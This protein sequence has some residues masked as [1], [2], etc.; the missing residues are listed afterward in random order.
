MA[1]GQGGTSFNDGA[2]ANGGTV[3][4]YLTNGTGD[5]ILS[6]CTV[7]NIPT[8]SG[9]AIGGTIQAI[10]TGN[11]YVNKGTTSAAN[12]VL[13]DSGTA[14][15]LPTAASD[16]TT[17]TG[18]SFDLTMS[19]LTTGK[20]ENIT[21][22]ALTTGS[23]YIA[24]LG[25]SLTTGG[26]FNAS[27]GAAITGYALSSTTTGV[28]TG[29]GLIQ[30]TANNATTG[31]LGFISGTGLTSGN[32]WVL[33]G[34]GANMT[35]AGQVQL[36][37]MGAATTGQG[38]QIT[39]TGAYTGLNGILQVTANSATTGTIA[40]INGTALTS[41]NGLYVVGGGA[42]MLTGGNV[43]NFDMGAA[44]AGSAILAQTSGVYIGTDGVLRISATAA[45]SGN[46]GVISVTGLTTG[47]GLLIN[48]T[49]ATLTT[50]RYLSCNDATSEVFGVGL[51]GHLI[52]VGTAAA[53]SILITTAQ[54]I[55][56]VALT[57]GATDTCGI[58]TST[59]TQNNTADST[60]TLTFGK[61]YTV[62]PK[63]V[64]ITASNASAALAAQ[65]GIYVSSISATAVVF[66]VPK[67]SAAGA[68]PSWRYVIIS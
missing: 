7:A 54:G 55:T 45:T 35:S 49:A 25:T 29:A 20:G 27:L 60:F 5:W 31:V 6:R 24:T 57:A 36:I 4:H 59:G 10:D 34:G 47:N 28:Y 11:S 41:G 21:A 67:S 18:T 61:T 43:G 62:A 14:F 13:L 32:I 17:T 16:A 19:T 68:T 51:N 63:G 53:P 30:I 23:A 9:Y 33:T 44:T 26:A 2:I 56:A 48:A 46:V 40:R 52:S 42:A 8:G 22:T 66:G 65:S 1:F 50:G 64:I 12:F 3:D 38:L 58:I 15:G 37:T 39:T